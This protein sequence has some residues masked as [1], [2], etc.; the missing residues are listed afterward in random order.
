[1]SDLKPD[2]NDFRGDCP[3]GATADFRPFVSTWDDLVIPKHRR[4]VVQYLTDEAGVNGL[5]LYHGDKEIS[6]EDPGLFPFGETLAKQARFTAGDA[7]SWGGG[8]EWPR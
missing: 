6:F 2:M 7:T 1:M 3:A 4:M 8:Y 5:H